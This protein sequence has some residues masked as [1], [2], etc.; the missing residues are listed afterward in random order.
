MDETARSNSPQ[1]TVLATL[2]IVAALYLL[3]PILIPIALSILLASLL[4]PATHLLRR[5]LPVGPF[6]AA[7]IL[8]V[9][10]AVAGLY[11]ASLTAESLVQAAKTFPTD[12]ERLA[13]KL[14]HLTNDA[15]R[16][17]P[18]LANILPEPGTISILGDTNSERLL[19][20][21]N[22]RLT[23][24]TAWV[25]HGVVVLFLVL[26]L[27]VE[28][29]LIVPRLVHLITVESGE[30]KAMERTLKNVTRKIRAYLL[31]R[32]VLNIGLGA[33]TAVAMLLLGIDFAVP[34]GLFAG[35]TNY[36]P[37]IGN[38]A[39]GAMAVLVTLAQRGS[40]ADCLIVTAIFLAIVT[41][42]GYLVMPYVMGRSLDLNGTTV[43]IACMFWGFL[44]GLMG[45]ILAIPIT[46]SVKLVFQH[47]HPL[48]HWAELM[49]LAYPLDDSATAPDPSPDPP[50]ARRRLLA[51]RPG[52]P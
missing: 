48:R 47:L 1:L 36:I 27:L 19:N 33:A 17:H 40:I 23:D 43:L 45:L 21:L 15:I 14:S 39:A 41:V 30:S 34:L 32:T 52:R 49:S 12:V 20:S 6:G 7:V 11:T 22:Y 38:V 46:V 42:E 35:L 18:Y 2:G 13:S 24:L 37:Y 3:K 29:D 50:P 10:M 8:F 4:S 28:G 9:L 16:D 44:W 51:R 26:F 31:A 25:G 5:L